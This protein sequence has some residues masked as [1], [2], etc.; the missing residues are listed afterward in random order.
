MK[1]E[2]TAKD[3]STVDVEYSMTKAPE[4]GATISRKGKRFTRLLPTSME[5]PRV[6]R[7]CH[8]V[9]HSL[10]RN[11]PRHKGEFTPEGKPVFTSWNHVNRYQDAASDSDTVQVEY[12]GG[13]K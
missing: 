5:R 12:E 4:F 2:F 10:P 7:D 9:S 13:Y 1:Y 8:I 11:D 6:K 3:G